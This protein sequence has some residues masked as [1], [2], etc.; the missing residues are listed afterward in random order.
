MENLSRPNS[1]L[2]RGQ[3][4]TAENETW[5]YR[6]PEADD[7]QVEHDLLFE[8]IRQDKPYNDAERCAKA[9]LASILGRMACY[10]GQMV[11]WDQAMASTLEL[12]PGLEQWT[13]LEAPAPILPDAQGKYPIPMPGITKAF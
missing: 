11:T 6:G 9:C 3:L 8:A 4:Q 13:S 7:Y 5:R 12:A 2:Y 1:R 10:S